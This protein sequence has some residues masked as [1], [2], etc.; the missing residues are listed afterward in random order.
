M[1]YDIQIKIETI[2]IENSVKKIRDKK[3]KKN[4]GNPT[5]QTQIILKWQ[6]KK[7][8]ADFQME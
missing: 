3:V 1:L 2:C 5:S 7:G 8:R 4:F 6:N